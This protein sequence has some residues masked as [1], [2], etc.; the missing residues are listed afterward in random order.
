MKVNRARTILVKLL[1]QLCYVFFGGIINTEGAQ[2]HLQLCL[3]DG[4]TT[5]RI[6]QVKSVLNFLLL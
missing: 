6:E 5:T 2:G 3:R 1:N 4:T